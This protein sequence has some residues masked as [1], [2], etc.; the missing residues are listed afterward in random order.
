M[1]LDDTVSKLVR[2]ECTPNGLFEASLNLKDVN[3]FNYHTGG[4]DVH[5]HTGRM[6]GTFK[7]HIQGDGD[8]IYTRLAIYLHDFDE[9][10]LGDTATVCKDDLVRE[11]EA[12]ITQLMSDTYYL[13][14][15]R[16]R[17]RKNLEAVLKPRGTPK[18]VIKVLD[19]YDALM[20]CAYELSNVDPETDDIFRASYIGPFLNYLRPDYNKGF[21]HYLGKF[22]SH[23]GVAPLFANGKQSGIEFLDSW[24]SKLNFTSRDIEKIIAREKTNAENHRKSLG[25]EEVPELVY[26]H[27][28]GI[29][30]FRSKLRS[31]Q[32]TIPKVPM[33]FEWKDRFDEI[34]IRPE[35][36]EDCARRDVEAMR[37]VN[38]VQQELF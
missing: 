11:Q 14:T 37:T 24:Y 36:F 1:F 17:F 33:Y 20:Y 13:G 23:E 35:D 7:R 8:D 18:R 6:C 38:L 19:T 27:Q 28:L 26:P 9:R 15:Q 5:T 16:G 30:N 3:R 34:E 4:G 21:Y 31:L 32:E 2:N 22:E 29:T 10:Y 25:Q 12:D